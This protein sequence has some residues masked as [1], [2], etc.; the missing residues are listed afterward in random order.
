ML[1]SQHQLIRRTALTANTN[2]YTNHCQTSVNN[3]NGGT[4]SS[5]EP[6]SQPSTLV[7][8]PPLPPVQSSPPKTCP[9]PESLD[10][11]I[12]D[13]ETSV[14]S[15]GKQS[16]ESSTEMSQSCNE[17]NNSPSDQK[18]AQL[19]KKRSTNSWLNI[20]NPTYKTRHEEFKRLF[21]N[22]VPNNERLVVDYS[23]ALQKEILVHGR[24]YLSLN[25]IS[26]YANIFKWETSLV[27]P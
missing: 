14:S 2:T 17:S 9:E 1:A 19:K 20:L 3:G 5:E 16:V 25:Y 13:N 27:S 18:R 24:L 21:S 10:N 6:L 23:C 22:L 7:S 4:N 8:V 26:F 15:N 12:T 11:S